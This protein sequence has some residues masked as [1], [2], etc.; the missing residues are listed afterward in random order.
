MCWRHC[1]GRENPADLPS[2]GMSPN[3]LAK[4]RLWRYGPDWLNHPRT[5]RD[6]ELEVPEDC[7][8]E[9]KTTHCP[10]HSLLT[11]EGSNSLSNIIRF[12]NHS[13]L[14]RLLRV[15]AYVCRFIEKVRAKIRE[16]NAKE[17]NTE[18]TAAKLN[19]AERLWVIGVKDTLNELRAK[20]WIN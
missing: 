1:P 19:K 5:S 12:E 10:T 13:N 9:I 16:V 2:R 20:F 18:L 14:L 17:L 15:T 3:E 8:K 11:A 6:E 7:L 4:S